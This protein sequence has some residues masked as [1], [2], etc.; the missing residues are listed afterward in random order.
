MKNNRQKNKSIEINSTLI[1]LFFCY[2]NLT[3]MMSYKFFPH[4]EDDIQAMLRLL[5]ISS[6]E[7]L[8][9]D[10]PKELR[11]HKALDLPSSK[12]ELEVRG[13]F[14]NLEK[15]NKTLK[16]FAGVGAYDHY[17]PSIITYIANRS[18][19]QTSYTP[20]QAEISQGTLQYIFEYQTM[21]ADLTGMDISNA[22]MYDGATATAEAMMM[23]VASSK[24]RKKV[25]VSSTLLPQTIKVLHTYAKF[26]HIDLIL[27]KSVEGTTSVDEIN[28]YLQNDDIAGVIV[29]LVNYYGIIEDLSSLSDVCHKHKALLIIN[30]PASP[31]GVLKSPGELGADIACGEAQSLGIPLSYG[32]PYIGYLCTND[33]L[34][35]KMPGRLVGGTVDSDGNRAFVLTMQAREQHIRREKATSNICTSQGLMCLYVAMY[36]SL[37]GTDGLREVNQMSFQG[38]HYL[39]DE[40]LKTHKFEPVFNKP[41]FNEFCLQLTSGTAQDL[42]DYCAGFGFLAGSTVKDHTNCI[43]FCVTEKNSKEDIDDLVKVIKSFNA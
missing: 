14:K 27:V 29:P 20:Y 19:F 9:K 42:I 30:S 36:L 4:T 25:L 17:T 12:S 40:L 2:I 32:G 8:Y 13:I 22:S 43:L 35:R 18:E 1:D 26:H 28:L 5:G 24:K 15:K 21:M 16:C 3:T 7:E 23:S 39:Y 37:M 31:L 10:V 33:S 41:F 11:L 38:A 6:I 34:V